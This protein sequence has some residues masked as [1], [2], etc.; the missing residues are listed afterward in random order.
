M[1]PPRI[2]VVGHVTAGEGDGA[3]EAAVA[4]SFHRRVTRRR[5]TMG[6]EGKPACLVCAVS[7]EQAPLVNLVYRGER[8]WI[9]PQHMPV[10][11]HNT[12]ELAARLAEVGGQ[13]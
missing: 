13:D 12:D 11:I 5:D 10:L 1:R 2:R 3:E 8:V 9:C 6:T 4:A 7:D